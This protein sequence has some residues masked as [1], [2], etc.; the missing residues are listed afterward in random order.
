MTDNQY[1]IQ[2]KSISG[3]EW[4]DSILLL[5]TTDEARTWVDRYADEAGFYTR[6]VNTETGA[7]VYER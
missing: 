6:A 3:D 4:G 1:G 7:V 5:D 2:I